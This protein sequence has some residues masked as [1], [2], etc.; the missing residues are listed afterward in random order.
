VPA[1]ATDPAASVAP[2][3]MPL[4]DLRCRRYDASQTYKLVPGGVGAVSVSH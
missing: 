2:R 4:I 1:V 3:D